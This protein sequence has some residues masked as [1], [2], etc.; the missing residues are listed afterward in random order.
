MSTMHIRNMLLALLLA[1]PGLAHAAPEVESN[2]PVAAAQALEI[3][4]IIVDGVATTGASV[5]GVVG[6]R[7]GAATLDLDFYTFAGSEGDVVTLDIDRG[8]DGARRVDTIIAI[9]GPAPAYTMLSTNDDSTVDPGSVAT[10]TTS[11]TTRDS[12]IVNFRL[13]ADGQ[14]TVGVSGFPRRWTHGGTVTSSTLG[15]NANGDY[16]LVVSG[17]TPSVMQIS[18]EIKPGSGQVAP[19][20][21]KA[22]GKV[23]VALLGSGEFSVEDVDTDTLKFGHSGTEASLSKCGT[24]SDLNG[25]AFP[26]LVCHFDNQAAEFVSSDE[27]AI[28]RGALDNGRKFEGR[29]WLKV[30]PVKAPD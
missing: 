2:H 22:R 25:D 14:Y 23:P 8:W 16:T 28:L 18:I 27:E 5:D 11:G 12:R 3:G 19:I 26:D 20:N 9:F 21:P 4:D 29:G 30:V 1:L 6:A 7:S 10:S 13:P 24:P 17:V 15:M